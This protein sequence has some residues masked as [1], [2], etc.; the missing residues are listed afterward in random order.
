V[1]SSSR[2]CVVLTSWPITHPVEPLVEALVGDRLAACVHV[3]PP[4]RSTY[5]WQG[6]LETAD[7]RPLTI[8]TTH[9][10]LAAVEACVS[11]RHPYAVPEWL[12]V[13]V[14]G[15]DAYVRWMVESVD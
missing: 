8:K 6:A 1:E 4:G 14:A 2:P 12:V 9:E 3:G 5:R 7:E 13:D 15:S 10:R 11:A